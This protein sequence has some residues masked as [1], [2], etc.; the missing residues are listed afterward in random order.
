MVMQYVFRLVNIDKDYFWNIDEM[1]SKKSYE[2]YN[3]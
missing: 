3:D 2:G 1:S